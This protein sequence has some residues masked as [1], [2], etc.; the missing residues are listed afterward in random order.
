MSNDATKPS[1]VARCV[2][3]YE[4]RPPLSRG[5]VIELGELT[6]EELTGLYLSVMERFLLGIKIPVAE[7]VAAL[8]LTDPL[9]TTAYGRLLTAALVEA[10]QNRQ[11][12][13]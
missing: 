9:D 7:R 10:S 3:A 4:N 8:E 5:K 11:V 13:R 6:N 2:R 1:L 12:K